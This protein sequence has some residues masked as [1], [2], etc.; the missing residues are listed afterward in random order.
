MKIISPKLLAV[1]LVLTSSIHAGNLTLDKAR[2]TVRASVKATGHKFEAVVTDFQY[3]IN[4]AVA[5]GKPEAIDYSFDFNDLKT[6][7]QGRDKEM[8][9]W[10]EYE[11]YPRLRYVLTAAHQNGNKIVTTG[12]LTFHNRTK[13]ISITME[14][15]RHGSDVKIVGNVVIDYTDFGLE[16]IKVLFLKVD[17]LLFVTFELNGTIR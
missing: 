1:F 17:P 6:G 3:D 15:E 8:L 12:N 4:V 11:K 2:S 5:D 16:I 13:T 9:Q 10:L 7:I 14:V